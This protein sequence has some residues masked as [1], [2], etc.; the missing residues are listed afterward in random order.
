MGGR[1]LLSTTMR[2]PQTYSYGPHPD[3][4]YDVWRAPDGG[5]V[6][7]LVYLHGGFWY[8]EVDRSH[9]TPLVT[10]LA[11]AG[12]DVVALEYRR[13]RERRWSAMHEDL[14]AGLTAIAAVADL[15]ASRIVIGHSAGGQLAAIA[16][17][18]LPVPLV[19]AI[20]LA[21]CLDLELA[22]RLG[23]GQGAVDDMLR[24]E[25]VD[26][27]LAADPVRRP[28]RVPAVALHGTADAVVPPALSESWV[29]SSDGRATLV[30]LPGFDHF[31][32]IE[33]R[34]GALVPIEAA[35]A[36]LAGRGAR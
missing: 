35:I 8:P 30:A 32:I 14:R 25:E 24:G 1:R 33:P 9:A 12:H 28:P 21:G 31:S 36:E 34:A 15:P 20:T 19:G 2:Q 11:A 16:A 18:E 27:A 4:V 13:P 17:A 6:H 29:R 23:L 5:A 26:E 3:Q 22:T 7:T 10:A